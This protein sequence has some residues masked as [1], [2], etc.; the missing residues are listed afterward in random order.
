MN[1]ILQKKGIKRVVY[2]V[3]EQIADDE[4]FK[5]IENTVVE[6]VI[7]RRYLISNYGRI[8]DTFS[9]RFVS[10]VYDKKGLK[11]DGNPKGYPICSIKYRDDNDIIQSK[12]VILSRAVAITFDPRDNYKE[13]E[14]NHLDGNHG[15]NTMAPSDT[16]LEWSTREENKKHARENKLYATCEHAPSAIMTNEQVESICKMILDGKTNKEIS[17]FTGFNPDLISNIRNQQS[18]KEITTK[19]DMPTFK[20]IEVSDETVIKTADMI[21]NGYTY[22]EISNMLGIPKSRILQIKAREFKPHLTTNYNFDICMDPDKLE[23][24]NS[25]CSDLESGI[26]PFEIE[27]KYNVSK[28]FVNSIISGHGY[29][30]ISENYNIPSFDRKLSDE[31]VINVCEELMKNSKSLAQISR[32]AGVPIKTVQ[33]IHNKIVYKYITSNYNFPEYHN[34]NELNN[35]QVID[36]CERLQ[37]G[38]S[39]AKISRDTGIPSSKIYHIR[40]RETHTDI[41][42]NYNW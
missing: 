39:T 42:K 22:D 20:P 4:E 38:D 31:L 35:D 11:H 25:I 29:K 33:D 13:L 30:Y 7:P 28:S 34:P 24:I 26:R 37:N 17:E 14:V 32:D 5:F 12:K 16:N 1:S 8:Y 41:S 23:L 36:I 6:N 10:E 27:E 15:H 19:Y 9:E 18:Y 40:Y 21:V 3:P 2:T